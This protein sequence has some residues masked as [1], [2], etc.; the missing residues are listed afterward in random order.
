MSEQLLT[1]KEACRELGGKVSLST[2]YNAVGN[3]LPHYRVSGSGRR[4]RGKI[5]VNRSDLFAWLEAQKV[6]QASSPPEAGDE[7]P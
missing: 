6:T 4:G 1:L 2:L 3:G 5:L 7:W